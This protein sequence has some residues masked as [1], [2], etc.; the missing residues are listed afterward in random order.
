MVKT[1]LYNQEGKKVDEIV[2]PDAV[3]GVPY[4]KDLVHQVALSQLANQRQASAHTKDR[5]EVS[6]GGRKPW[7]QKGTGRARHGSTRSPIW[8]GGGVVFGPRSEKG[9]EKAIPVAMRRK[10]LCMILSEK[11]RKDKVVV[12]DSLRFEK[13]RTKLFALAMSTLPCAAKKTL[14]ALPAMNAAVLLSARNYERAHTIQAKDLNPADLLRFPYLVLPK[15]S[16][17][18]I[19]KTFTIKK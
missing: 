2:L 8:K 5:S 17:D 13:P 7:R 9:Y 11:A 16:I 1:P 15:E 19:V 4:N 18:V 12:L 14:V 6:G 3:F 10:A